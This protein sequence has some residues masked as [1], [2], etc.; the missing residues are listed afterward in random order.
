MCDVCCCWYG[1]CETKLHSQYD[2]LSIVT[3]I[4]ITIL[5]AIR[6]VHRS[7][8][9]L[10][11]EFT[12]RTGQQAEA[13]TSS[14]VYAE[15]VGDEGTSGSI[16]LASPVRLEEWHWRWVVMLTGLLL[17]VRVGV[18]RAREPRQVRGMSEISD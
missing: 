12:V 4:L 7:R 18:H 11:Y 3:H 14:R 15:M 17:H 10:V 2:R 9:A 13:G 8:G 1:G 6:H 5:I 16:A